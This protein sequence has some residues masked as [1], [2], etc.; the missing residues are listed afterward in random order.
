MTAVSPVLPICL[1]MHPF[2]L[3]TLNRLKEELEKHGVQI[4]AQGQSTQDEGDSSWRMVSPG[5][6]G[7]AEE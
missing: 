4:L 5:A 2:S 3:F 6:E 1:F 7:K